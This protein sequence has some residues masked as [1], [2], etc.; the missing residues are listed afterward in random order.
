MSKKVLPVAGKVLPVLFSVVTEIVATATTKNAVVTPVVTA[1]TQ[2]QQRFQ[3][4]VTTV[5]TEIDKKSKRG[6]IEKKAPIHAYIALY[7]A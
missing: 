1:E 7:A 5:T 4:F 6:I 3:P 2:Q